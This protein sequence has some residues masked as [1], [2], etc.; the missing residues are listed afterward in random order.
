MFDL[1]DIA[2][3]D[4][5]LFSYRELNILLDVNS[6]SIHVLDDAASDLFQAIMDK[7]DMDTMIDK[8]GEAAGQEAYQQLL[9]IQ[10]EGLLGSKTDLDADSLLKEASY[11]KSLCL[12]VSHD[13]NLRCKY[14]FAGTGDFGGD[15][16]LM[17][18]DTAKKAIDFLLEASGPRPF[19]EVDFF[20]GEPLM[21]FDVVK[22]AVIYAKEASRKIGKEIRLTLTTNGML[23]NEQVRRFLVEHK[24]KLVLSLDGRAEVNDFMRP[25][26][27]GR[28]SYERII[29]NFQ[30]MVEELDGMDYY[31][32]GT[33]TKHNL[34]F[35]HDVEHM[36]GLGFREL[37]VEPVVAPEKEAY[38]ISEEDFSALS[39]EYDRLVDLYLDYQQKGDPFN[40][41]HFNIN[42]EQ[43]PCLSKRLRGCGAGFE[44]LAVTP[45]GD[46]Y[47]CHQFV[48]QTEFCLGNVRE[49]VKNKNISRTFKNT[50]IFN[51]KECP[52]CWVR[53]YCSGGC[54]ANAYQQNGDLLTPYKT[55]CLVQKKRLEC[56]I[57]LKVKGML[58]AEGEV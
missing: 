36:A 35:S 12:H 13:C 54:N 20:G 8:Y 14:C 33:Y 41:F 11:I 46:L 23:L 29:P 55:E 15:R 30:S 49:G 25:T 32:R 3:E 45:R 27:S 39:E 17:S 9:A 43:G 10:A 58:N 24:I 38:A 37:S 1:K 31:L 53:F 4:V 44:Y 48:G 52:R 28:G 2:Q 47:P 6:G 50:H 26:V 42:L 21:N 40:F 5:H 51:K 7:E 18:I 22:D 19:C 16:Q 57:Y 34:D 56:A